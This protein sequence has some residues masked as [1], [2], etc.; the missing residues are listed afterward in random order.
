MEWGESVKDLVWMVR[1]VPVAP[2]LMLGGEICEPGVI[3]TAHFSPEAA[4]FHHH[5]EFC[6][7]HTCKVFAA[8]AWVELGLEPGQPGSESMHSAAAMAAS[9]GRAIPAAAVPGPP[10]TG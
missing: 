10:P 2:L 4:A 7:C 8:R 9:N 3:C 5:I 6:K 1:G